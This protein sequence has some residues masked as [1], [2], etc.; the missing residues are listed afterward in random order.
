MIENDFHLDTAMKLTVDKIAGILKEHGYKL[1][2]QRQAVLEVIAASREHLTPA[3]LYDR[4]RQVHPGIGL[5]TI[6]RTLD[7]LTEL[8]LLCRVHTEGNCQNYLIRRRPSEHHHHII[9]SGCGMV[10]DFIDCD[11]GELEQR[12]SME[13]GFEMEGHLLEFRGLCRDCHEDTSA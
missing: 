12:L 7:I 2:P 6:Y 10:V 1:T 5:V 9:C 13:T 4:V 8:D 3:A 11:L